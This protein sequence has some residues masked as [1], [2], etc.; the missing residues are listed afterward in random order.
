M[1]TSS[2]GSVGSLYSI[3]SL[4]QTPLQTASGVFSSLRWAALA[5]PEIMTCAICMP[6][7]S[8]S[9]KMYTGRLKLVMESADEAAGLPWRLSTARNQQGV[10]L[11]MHVFLD[12]PGEEGAFLDG[13]DFVGT[14]C[15]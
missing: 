15:E 3:M 1:S 6:H 10:M 5:E 9:V 12:E 8:P 14:P 13:D 11:V 7:G 2:S 4:A